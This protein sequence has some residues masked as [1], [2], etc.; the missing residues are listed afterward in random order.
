MTAHIWNSHFIY[1]K[2]HSLMSIFF[3]EETYFHFSEAYLILRWSYQATPNLIRGKIHKQVFLFIA[4]SDNCRC[5]LEENIQSGKGELLSLCCQFK[6]FRIKQRKLN[7]S[8]L[9]GTVGKLAVY[10]WFLFE[11]GWEHVKAKMSCKMKTRRKRFLTKWG[12]CFTWH[13]EFYAEYLR[14]VPLK[15]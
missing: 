4:L 8:E 3:P 7:R 14:Q 2:G 1:Y 12:M 5:F 15:L 10:L 6:A 9:L 11:Q 13:N